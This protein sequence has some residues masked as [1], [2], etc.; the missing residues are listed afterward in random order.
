MS[1]ISMLLGQCR[2]PRGWMGRFLAREMNRAH[3]P[4]TDWV[5]S[6]IPPMSSGRVLDV[7]CGG[8]GAMRK[9]AGLVPDIKIHGVDYSPDS[10]LVATR[11]NRSLIQQGRVFVHQANVTHIPYEDE[12]FELVI[13]V[14]SHFFWADLQEA[15][16]EIRRVLRA[17]GTVAL[18]GGVY[19]GG[20][21]DSRNRRFAKTGGMN[22]QTLPELAN[23]IAEAGYDDVEVREDHE[24]GWSCVMGHRPGVALTH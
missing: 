5:L 2:R 10:L 19:L 7:G 21:F 23:V 14:E 1:L 6:Q 4:M 9:L 24:R 22:C 3:A 13:A 20:K 16:R 11:T 17:G 12:Y 18:A 15:L 8:G